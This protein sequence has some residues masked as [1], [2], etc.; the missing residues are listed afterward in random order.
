MPLEKQ[1]DPFLACEIDGH[2]V[3]YRFL[4]LEDEEIPANDRMVRFARRYIA[5]W[6]KKNG[7]PPRYHHLLPT[8]WQPKFLIDFAYDD[9]LWEQTHG[10]RA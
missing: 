10:S 2:L 4:D 5:H 3:R 9:Y 8:Q 6:I 7:T 1:K